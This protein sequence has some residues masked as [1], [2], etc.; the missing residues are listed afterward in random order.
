ERRVHRV[1][2]RARKPRYRHA[3]SEQDL[4]AGTWPSTPALEWR[5][6]LDRLVDSMHT[7]SGRALAAQRHAVALRFCESL[8]A[9]YLQALSPNPLNPQG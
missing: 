1:A 6:K 7:A 4:A 2:G 9:E 5:T 8:Q 3:A